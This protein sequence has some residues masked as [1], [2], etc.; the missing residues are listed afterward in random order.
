MY[1][2]D[3]IVLYKKDVCKV[4][5]IKVNQLSHEKV[6][7]LRPVYSDGTET[8]IEVP[9]AN[10][11]GN[12]RDLISM[13][14]LDHLICAYPSIEVLTTKDITIKKEYIQLLNSNKLEDL[15][16]IIKTTYGKNKKRRED[17]LKI[18]SVDD[19]YFHEAEKILYHQ[20]GALLNLSFDDTKQ[21]MTEQW[22][23]RN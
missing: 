7:L 23:K 21:Y 10:R 13:E 17:N 15:V 3:D 19:T 5:K 2:V 1:K 14:E 9:I 12:L 11:A 16:C 6:Y 22:E 8:V 18:S 4:L 20:I